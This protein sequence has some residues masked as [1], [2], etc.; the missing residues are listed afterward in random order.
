MGILGR[1]VHA[2][3]KEYD[4]R[5]RRASEVAIYGMKHGHGHDDAHGHGH[6]HDDHDQHE[7]STPAA[8]EESHEDVEIANVPP[9][10]PVAR[11]RHEH[12]APDQQPTEE[13]TTPTH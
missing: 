9:G 11:R 4:R 12:R 2:V 8:E 3:E 6:G 13:P 1:F 10:T 5:I 7:A